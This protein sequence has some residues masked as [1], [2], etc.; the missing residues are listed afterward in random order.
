MERGWRLRLRA[1]KVSDSARSISTSSTADEL[2][3]LLAA[4]GPVFSD[5]DLGV[6]RPLAF[7]LT[8]GRAYTY[9][10]SAH[11]SPSRQEVSSADTVVELDYD[12]WCAFVWELRS[13]FAM[14]YADRITVARG[15]FGQLVRWEPPLRVAFDGQAI[16]DIDDPATGARTTQG[17]PLD[18]DSDLHLD[19]SDDEI[20]DFLQRAG[21]VHLR[22]VVDDD[23]VEALQADVA[24]AST[25]PAPT[26][27]GRGGR[28]SMAGRCATGST[29][30]TTDRSASPAWVATRGSPAS[31]PSAVPISV[32]RVT[33]WT[34]TAW[35]S[36][37]PG[38]P[39]AWSTSRGTG[40]AA[41]VA[42]R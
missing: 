42:I 8:D 1:W 22:Q 41:W 40:T 26:T 4:R 2:P 6:V 19:D 10:P 11:T 27:G 23:E 17:R 3:A 34:G 21:F 30:S 15:S 36:R 7:Q 38:P 18:L 31:P 12:E 29:T 32:M 37:S 35:S 13:C 39:R 9:V 5:S 24:E 28:P 25:P 14:F 20:A 16:Y 33:A